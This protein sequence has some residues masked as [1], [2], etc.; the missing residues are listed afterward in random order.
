MVYTQ[1]S[2]RDEKNLAN[3]Y[4]FLKTR[5]KTKRILKPKGT[6]DKDIEKYVRE[7]IKY[8]QPRFER[9][10][11]RKFFDIKFYKIPT[12]YAPIDSN[13]VNYN[14]STGFMLLP[15][16]EMNQENI[17][18]SMNIIR[19]DDLAV[20]LL[21]HL[22]NNGRKTI[23]ELVK[24]L[25]GYDNNMLILLVARLEEDGYLKRVKEKEKGKTI[26]TLELVEKEKEKEDN[27]KRGVSIVDELDNRVEN[28]DEIKTLP[29][30]DT[31]TIPLFKTKRQT[32]E[33]LEEKKETK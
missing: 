10:S 30:D 14:S 29:L 21:H 23:D 24:E 2:N 11:G 17:T 7:M 27:N 18:E 4:A 5:D 6:T 26:T 15:G 9:K 31:A 1:L 32:T 33:E 25:S 12:N 8:K 28:I 20:L 16:M 19:E 22:F 3:N 13:L